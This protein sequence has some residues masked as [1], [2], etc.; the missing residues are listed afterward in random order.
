MSMSSACLAQQ[1]CENLIPDISVKVLS[2]G[3]WG[4]GGVR[5]NGGPLLQSIWRCGKEEEG[6][7]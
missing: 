2:V 4:G 3:G 5:V 6:G 7:K 1:V